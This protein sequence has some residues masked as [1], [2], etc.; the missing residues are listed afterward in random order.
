MDQL[1][2]HGIVLQEE[3]EKL[4]FGPM[5]LD[6]G[7]ESPEEIALSILAEVKAVMNGNKGGHLRSKNGPIHNHPN[8]SSRP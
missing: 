7:A 5:G 6:L 3:D 2:C 4:I 8:G 1:S